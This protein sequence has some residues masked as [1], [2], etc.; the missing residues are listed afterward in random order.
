MV[1]MMLLLRR[2]YF[3]EANAIWTEQ[4]GAKMSKLC[5][6]QV[7]KFIFILKIHLRIKLIIPLDWRYYF[8]KV[9][10]LIC[11]YQ[12]SIVITFVIP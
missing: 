11:R 3:Y 1:H 2:E 4:N 10:G 5:T 12:D 9:R 8:Q 6:K 7:S